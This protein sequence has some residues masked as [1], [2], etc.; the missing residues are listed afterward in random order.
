MVSE[1]RTRKRQKGGSKHQLVLLLLGKP[2]GSPVS[3]SWLRVEMPL[4]G[5][6][7]CLDPDLCE[8]F[9]DIDD[10]EPEGVSSLPGPQTNSSM[11]CRFS[12]IQILIRTCTK[13]YDYAPSSATE[14]RGVQGYMHC[15]PDTTT[16][17]ILAPA[18]PAPVFG[19]LSPLCRA[20]SWNDKIIYGVR[21]NI[22][23]IVALD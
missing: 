21:S 13:A 10:G 6:Q 19:D 7:V 23:Q 11:V 5:L 17:L 8:E 4:L 18:A 14:D 3:R 1:Q 12:H 20:C 16:F 2:H 15:Q 9:S 22:T